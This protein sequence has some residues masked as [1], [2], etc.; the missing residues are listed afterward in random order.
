MNVN[1][2]HAS[3]KLNINEDLSQIG[4]ALSLQSSSPTVTLKPIALAAS[5]LP[6]SARTCL[7]H[8]AF[9]NRI[10]RPGA[11]KKGV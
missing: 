7:L 1:F 6:A 8:F 9:L 10:I 11:H 5:G 3:L 4:K 2:S